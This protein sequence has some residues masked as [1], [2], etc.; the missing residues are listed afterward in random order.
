[1]SDMTDTDSP[2]EPEPV[3]LVEDEPAPYRE[4]SH[5]QNATRGA[6]DKQ[7]KASIRTGVY[8]W[9]TREDPSWLLRIFPGASRQMSFPHIGKTWQM[10]PQNVE[11]FSRGGAARE[12][13]CWAMRVWTEKLRYNSGNALRAPGPGLQG[14]QSVRI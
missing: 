9:Q 14:N 5:G 7:K 1:M 4:I 2:P 3:D 6:H 13:K 12:C 8:F 11:K 10:S